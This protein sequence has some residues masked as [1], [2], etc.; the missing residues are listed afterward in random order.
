[1]SLDV[2]RRHGAHR[3]VHVHVWMIINDIETMKFAVGFMIPGRPIAMMMY[4]FLPFG[5]KTLTELNDRFKT[6]GYITM[7]QGKSIM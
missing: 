2:K 5:G 1:M 3:S 7:A 6:Y 4:D